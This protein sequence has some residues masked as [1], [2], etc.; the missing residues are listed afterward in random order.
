M[1]GDR[2]ARA[3]CGV[4]RIARR[5]E[6]DNRERERR[7][8]RACL[9]RRI[10]CGSRAVAGSCDA[11][12]GRAGR[13]SA[14]VTVMTY[15]QAALAALTQEMERDPTVWVLGEDLGPEG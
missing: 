8:A 15:A 12:Y 9:T 3:D 2:A 4:A 13:G 5:V 11:L 1:A 10:R 14:L 7:G 6:G